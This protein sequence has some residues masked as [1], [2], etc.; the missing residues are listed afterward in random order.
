MRVHTRTHSERG[1]EK[2]VHIPLS[3]QALYAASM[4]CLLILHLL[5]L[6]ILTVLLEHVHSLQSGLHLTSL[7]MIIFFFHFDVEMCD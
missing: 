4:K 6:W 2:L 7:P 1:R 3:E 5:L